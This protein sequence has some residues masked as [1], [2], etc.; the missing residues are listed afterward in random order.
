MF[1]FVTLL[2]TLLQFGTIS[3]II[4]YTERVS[5]LLENAANKL[6]SLFV[7]QNIIKE[8]DIRVY[9]YGIEL[10]LSALV[11][12]ACLMLIAVLT[13]TVWQTMLYIIAFGLVRMYAGGIHLKTHVG[14]VLFMLA[15]YGVFLLSF[16][17]IP[18]NIYIFYIPVILIISYV[19]IIILSPVQDKNKPLTKYE[20]YNYRKRARILSTFF[21]VIAIFFL[22]FPQC[23]VIS[24]WIASALATTTLFVLLGYLKNK[25]YSD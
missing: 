9:A 25:R 10:L 12:A 17:I 20:V 14:C 8:E 13:A 24:F 19:I 22:L 16:F 7:K 18:P 2:Q 15:F 1:D 4:F 21:L 6:A 3:A 5:R 11:N 23:R